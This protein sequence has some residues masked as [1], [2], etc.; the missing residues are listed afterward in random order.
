MSPEYLDRLSPQSQSDQKWTHGEVAVFGS[1]VYKIFALKYQKWRTPLASLAPCE[2]RNTKKEVI[3]EKKR[4]NVLITT[5]QNLIF[6]FVVIYRNVKRRTICIQRR[7]LCN[8][9]A[10]P[11]NIDLYCK[12]IRIFLFINVG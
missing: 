2:T 9:P 4:T 10:S 6:L 5:I 11:W 7:Q 3:Y 12:G 1:T 8:V